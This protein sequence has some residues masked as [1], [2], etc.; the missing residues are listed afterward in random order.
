MAFTALAALL[1][2]IPGPAAIL[3]SKNAVIRGRPAAIAT[4]CGVLAADLIWAMAS[5][6]G[7]TG[8]LAAS[9]TAFELIRVAGATYLFYL[10][11]RLVFSK[12]F[13]V[14]QTSAASLRPG[15]LIR[16]FREGLLCD[17]SNPKT[18][19]VFA[20]VIPQFLGETNPAVDGLFLGVIFAAL[21]FCSLLSYAF[22]FGG[23]HFLISNAKLTRNLMRGSGAAL[24][25][26]GVAL[27]NESRT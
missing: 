10:A 25:L 5:V 23:T 3:T 19:L 7:L 2:A 16:G 17:L 26:F 8:L 9:H 24:G 21:G 12:G 15:G 14:E 11:V 22:L 20:S 18:V 27:L 1:V 13:S 4:A 6:A